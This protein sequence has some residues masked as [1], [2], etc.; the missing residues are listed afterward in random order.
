VE[1][2]LLTY[3]VA[4]AEELHFG[5]AAK[6]LNI[7]QPPLSQQ[8]IQL[9]ERIGVKLFTRTRRRVELTPAGEVLL[10]DA[11]KILALSGEAARRARRAGKGE[12]GRLAVGY[13]GSANYSVL[14]DLIREFRKRFPEVEL[15]LAELNTSQQIEAL[16]E[17]RIHVGLMRP[18]KGLENE[19]LAFETVFRELLIAAIPASHKLKGR[20]SIQ[21]KMLA[22]EPFIM[23]PRSRGPGFFDQII[24]MCQA[25]GFSP[26]IALEASQFHTII[27]MVAAGVGI[28]I[29]P[30]SMQRSR[31]KGVAFRP[32]D[33]GP[34]TALTMAWA[35]S[36]K[37]PVLKK[38]VDMAGELALP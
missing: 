17:G 4:V 27:G 13:I 24:A 31:M 28:T 9:E 12:T 1:S 16:R 10:E 32:I 36:N 23:I 15:S 33:N 8:I 6:R 5:R 3:F 34:E 37:S 21:L 11:R 22:K 30:G 18:P 20:A 2:R 14:P 35:S 26:K 19:D 7:S 38:F 25:E 29:V